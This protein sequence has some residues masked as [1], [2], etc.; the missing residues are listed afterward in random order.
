V[1]TPQ[2]DI[3]VSSAFCLNASRPRR[4][5]GAKVCGAAVESELLTLL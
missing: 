1:E 4:S 2:R 5:H 3:S